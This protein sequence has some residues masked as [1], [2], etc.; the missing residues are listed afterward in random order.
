MNDDLTEKWY[1]LVGGGP[2]QVRILGHLQETGYKV[3]LTDGNID[4]SG[5]ALANLFFHL[6]IHDASGHLLIIDELSQEI[7]GAIKGVS[8]IATD[9]HKT[10]SI[11]ATSL[12]LP[13]IPLPISELIGDKDKLRSILTEIGIKQPKFFAISMSDSPG[14]VINR[15]KETFKDEEKIIIKP[16]GWSASKGIRVLEEEK[17]FSSEIETALRISRNGIAVI[18]EVV[19]ADGKLASEISIET[20]V[21]DGEISF[22]SAVDRIFSSDLVH[23]EDPRVPETLNL[24]V[25]FGIISPSSRSKSDIDIVIKDLQRLLN[26]LIRIGVYQNETF[27]LKADILFSTK[28]PIIIEA[29]P[30]TSGGWDSSYTSPKRGLR[31]QELAVQISLGNEVNLCDWIS[32]SPNYV[33]VVSDANSDSIDCLGRSFFGGELAKD[34]IAALSSA[35]DARDAN[36]FL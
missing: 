6:D 3:I 31:I 5:K 22:L 33:A 1:W 26:H 10:V 34:P 8:C 12:K 4:C 7:K 28:G 9:A 14:E 35:L 36:Q 30:R 11:I 13:G 19:F 15:I 17:H 32:G 23:I 20:L 27:I 24:G 21:R 18:E 25:E 29:T 2:M 16:L